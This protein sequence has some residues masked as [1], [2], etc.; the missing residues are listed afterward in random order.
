MARSHQPHD[1]GDG[2]TAAF[3]PRVTSVAKRLPLRALALVAL[4]AVAY[5]YSLLTLARGL[6]L[7]TPL[8]YLGLVPVIALTL[9]WFRLSRDATVRPIHDRQL[10]YIVGL[11]FVVV[12]AAVAFFLP[13]SL[14]TQFW[15]YRVDLLSLPLFVAGLV[16]LFYGVRKLWA[17]KFPIGFLLLAW[18]VPYLPLVGDGMQRFTDFT[19][20]A[21]A[22]IS[23]LVPIAKMAS[24]D[25]LFMVTYSGQSFPLSVGSACAG[26]NSLVGFIL[27]GTALAY[28]VRGPLLRRLVW[29]AI[30]LALVWLLNVVRIEAIFLVG[31]AFGQ[32]AAIDVLHPVAG[33]IIFNVG[34]FAMLLA[35][36]R[37]GLTFVSVAPARQNPLRSSSP[38]ARVR[39]ALVLSVA[40]AAALAVV[41]AGYARYEPLVNA[42]GQAQLKP[43]D[44][45]SAQI[46]RWDSTFVASFT[47]GKQFFGESSTWDRILYSSTSAAKLQA[48]VPVYVDVISTDDPNAL[49]AYGL[50]ACY[51]FHGFHIESL[52]P[53]DV[54]V[55]V[56]AQVI[57]YHN[58]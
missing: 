13:L 22:A 31:T 37:F 19:I 58:A 45:R 10:D 20:A 12:A 4:V 49:E 55:S 35:A 42:V 41:N 17:L 57:D 50:E 29:L 30:G 36:P 27:V 1:Y 47:Q 28:V 8:A 52:T 46:A 54:G 38:V 39:S 32:H 15:L 18:P 14:A 34:V 26:V 5:H 43:F 16:A 23:R 21:L 24:D 33:L 2:M 3:S 51:R 11:G 40:I 7:Q 53:A 56:P 25:G 6:T 44:I 48:S 9:G